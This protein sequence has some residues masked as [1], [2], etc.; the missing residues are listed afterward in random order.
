[1]KPVGVVLGLSVVKRNLAHDNAES[2]VDGRAS[3]FHHGHGARRISLAV[4]RHLAVRDKTEGVR[5]AL[6]GVELG[7]GPLRAEGCHGVVYA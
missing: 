1:M 4:F 3:V 6:Y 7:G 5:K 2:P